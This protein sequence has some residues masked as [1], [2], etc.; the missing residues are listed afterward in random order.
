MTL[1]DQVRDSAFEIERLKIAE[2]TAERQIRYTFYGVLATAILGLV[3]QLLLGLQGRSNAIDNKAAIVEA[4]DAAS[5]AAVKAE[6]AAT[7]ATAADKTAAS[8]NAITTKWWAERTGNPV[9][10]A[11]A[12]AAA[13]RVEAAAPP[14]P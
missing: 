8:T 2:R 6:V 14:L 10:M 7:K 4:K 11:K 1:Q 3:G 12:E 13:E 5:T 9:D